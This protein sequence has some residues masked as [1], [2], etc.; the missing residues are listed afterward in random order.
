M[1][2]KV[3]DTILEKDKVVKIGGV[4]YNVAPPSIATLILFSKYTAKLPKE[5]LD[6]DNAIASLL[7]NA[8]MLEAVGGAMASLILGAEKFETHTDNVNAIR[9]FGGKSW[10]NAETV[11][12]KLAKELNK[13][14]ID[15]IV[16]AFFELLE[17]MNLKS[18]F[19]LTTSLIEMNLT[20]PT[21][22]VGTT[23]S[24]Q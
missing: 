12:E 4:S 18:F 7:Q 8:P 13:A 14:P 10:K 19:Q 17:F 5:M 1:E 2:S 23:A 20:K 16:K 15:D 9:L 11:G 21:K 24:G 22:E 6:S 3:A